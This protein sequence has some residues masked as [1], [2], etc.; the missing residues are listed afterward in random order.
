MLWNPFDDV[1]PRNLKP[2]EEIPDDKPQQKTAKPKK[3][4]VHTTHG[5]YSQF[6]CQFVHVT[7]GV[8]YFVY[9]EDQNTVSITMI[10]SI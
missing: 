7:L 5:A 1:V 2:K 9:F 10:A 4:V 3:Y 8:Q 6:Y